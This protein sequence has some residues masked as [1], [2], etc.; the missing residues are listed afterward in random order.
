MKKKIVVFT[1]AGISKESGVE[2]FRDTD[3]L[4]ENHK[5]EDI[6]DI[7]AWDK[8]KELM[9]EFY[10][11]RRKQLPTV[12]PNEAHR[13]LVRLEEKYDVSIV[14]QNVDDLHERAGSKKVLHLHGQLTKAK[15]SSGKDNTSKHIG[16]EDIKI[17]DLCEDGFQMRPDIVWFGE[18]VPMIHTAQVLAYDS[19]IFIVI[20]TSLV[21]YPAAGI[22]GVT[23][24]ET[25]IYVVNPNGVPLQ[26]R[27]KYTTFIKEVAT[28]GTK[29]LVDKL[30]A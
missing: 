14:T 1:G 2:T 19:D 3:G 25:P 9:I 20:G 5:V 28:K 11:A 26:G 16:Y 6:A 15:S 12:E 22:L 4:W 13:Q 17:G 7:K 29:E 23:K 30:M 18:L 8:N 21:V 24:S 10:N 27:K